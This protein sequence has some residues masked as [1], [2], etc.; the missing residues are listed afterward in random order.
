M[1]NK[2]SAIRKAVTHKISYSGPLP[3]AEQMSVYE[4]ILPGS[5]ERILAMAEKQSEHRQS[6]EYNLVKSS[7]F[8]AKLGLTFG[9]IIVLI[10]ILS[11]SFLIY[12][13]KS[14]GV[15]LGSL[16]LVSLLSIF[17]YGTRG[18]SQKK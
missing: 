1:K 6:L 9:F 11:S 4:K 16:S 8:D 2:Q 15:W 14:S 3:P 17:V 10:S 7:I 12:F 18:I 13:G 5:A